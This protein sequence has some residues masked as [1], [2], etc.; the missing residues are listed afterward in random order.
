MSRKKR[1]AELGLVA[2]ITGVKIPRIE[3]SMRWSIVSLL[4]LLI[5]LSAGLI[6]LVSYLGGKQSTQ[7]LV[8][9]L[10]E[11]KAYRFIDKSSQFLAEAKTLVADARLSTSKLN[12]YT[13]Q[14]EIEEE[15]VDIFEGQ[16]YFSSVYMIRNGKAKLAFNQS[17]PEPQKPNLLEEMDEKAVE[18]QKEKL[19][20]TFEERALGSVSS[21]PWAQR[22][23]A[24][25]KK[26]TPIHKTFSN[27]APGFTICSPDNLAAGPAAGGVCVDIHLGD[28][29]LYIGSIKVGETG[30][31]FLTNKN[32]D[33]I[34]APQ[35]TRASDEYIKDV[36]DKIVLKNIVEFSNGEIQGAYAA[37][38][39]KLKKLQKKKK[40]L[41]HKK[42][43]YFDFKLDGNRYVGL[44]APFPAYTGLD[45]QTG[46]IIPEDEFFYFVRRNT[47]LVMAA[48]TVLILLAV[49]L[50]YIFSRRLAR[51]LSELS[52]E[53]EK[54]Q[55]FDLNSEKAIVS[56]ITDVQNMVVSFYKMR[57][58][59]RSFGKFVPADIVRQ[60]IAQEG[61]AHL[62]GDKRELTVHFSDI[63]GFTTVSESLK[64]E[65]LV[66]LLAEYLGEMS[67]IIAEE[68][69]TV[70]KY[71]GDA[72]MA[73]WGAPQAVPDHAVRAAHAALRC[74][75]R[76][77]ELEA[78]WNSEGKPVF[79]AR[80]GL[81]TGE[82]IVGN[83][84]SAERLNY[85]VIGDA[86]NLASRLEGINKYYG[87]RIIV[88]ETTQKLIADKFVT[89]L[90]D[91]VAV[92][93]KNEA[94]RI[95]ELV[96]EKGKVEK[97]ALDFIAHFEK[98]I[99]EYRD[100]KWNEAE[101]SLKAAQAI[102]QDDACELFLGRIAEYRVNPPSAGWSGEYVMK[103]K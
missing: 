40:W 37:M 21:F 4:T 103:T 69:G 24:D 65:D 5:L 44:F 51:P 54:I 25:G 74:Q 67:R 64:P 80:I 84:G 73:F 53:M 42:P 36:P 9:T 92:K 41:K 12:A 13:Q 31:A 29:A 82:I 61:D 50:G 33:V 28:L 60:L 66:E 57:Q 52:E 87:T 18:I 75:T 46:V 34:A 47:R 98:A 70:D 11:D 77:L 23:Y 68:N 10:M 26:L 19:H 99:S 94:I 93:G 17:I 89:R 59:L 95:Y 8:D 2:D 90:L 58:G 30:K 101:K 72:V 85:T 1:T 20:V 88:G 78:K 3:L 86:V 76:L 7:F 6:I 32:Y 14:K 83:M 45:W 91:F 15:L 96:G 43:F 39:K 71:I 100:Q 35:Q 97:D 38:K 55:T 102:R 63:E 81:N 48:S 22:E 27:G 16:P 79:R 49:V 62:Q 56:S